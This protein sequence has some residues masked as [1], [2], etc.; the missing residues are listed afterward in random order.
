M[1]DV[2]AVKDAGEGVNL[3]ALQEEMEDMR[4]FACFESCEMEF[5]GAVNVVKI[6]SSDSVSSVVIL[7]SE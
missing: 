2:A 7:L 1:V 5:G 6:G 4:G 3:E